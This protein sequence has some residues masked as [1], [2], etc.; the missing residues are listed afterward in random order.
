MAACAV[1]LGVNGH[2]T[3]VRTFCAP[4]SD[5]RVLL[6]IEVC[7]VEEHARTEPQFEMVRKT[8]AVKPLSKPGP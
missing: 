4:L 7:P 6:I 8:L 2:E 3:F 1:S 5:G